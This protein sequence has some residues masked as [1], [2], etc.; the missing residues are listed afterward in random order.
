MSRPP[1]RAATAGVAAETRL[2][3]ARQVS[4]ASDDQIDPALAVDTASGRSVLA[5]TD[6]RSTAQVATAP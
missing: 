3:Q 6:L 2:E 1:G 5:R 4:D